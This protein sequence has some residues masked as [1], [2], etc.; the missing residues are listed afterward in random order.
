MTNKEILENLVHLHR[1]ARSF[2]DGTIKTEKGLQRIYLN[3]HNE[4]VQLSAEVFRELADGL[5]VKTIY[6]EKDAYPFELSFVFKDVEFFALFSEDEYTE[7]FEEA[8]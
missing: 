8:V 7:L 4:R 3:G 2:Y 5:V 6:N 1:L